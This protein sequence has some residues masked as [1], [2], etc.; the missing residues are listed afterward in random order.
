[1][2]DHKRGD[3]PLADYDHLPVSALRDRIRS[4]RIEEIEQLLAYEQAHGNRL[5]VVTTMRAR[6]E[7]LE[8]GATPTSG[9][10][11]VRPEQPPPPAAGSPVSTDTAAEPT[12]PAPHGEP[13]QPGDPDRRG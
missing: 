10:H 12:S 9:Q 6:L 2:T 1:M 3:L 11:E 8:A 7:Q 5:P 4:L 13:A